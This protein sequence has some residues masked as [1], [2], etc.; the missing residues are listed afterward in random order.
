MIGRAMHRG[1]D[2]GRPAARRVKRPPPDESDA[3]E[4]EVDNDE[5]DEE[6]RHRPR[7][8][9]KTA[10]VEAQP[11]PRG[12]GSSWRTSHS[13]N[14]NNN[15]NNNTTSR[16][17]RRTRSWED[18]EADAAADA[19]GESRSSVDDE[20]A[21]IHKQ[22]QHLQHDPR[23]EA[24]AASPDAS[25]WGGDP[26]PEDGPCGGGGRARVRLSKCW[27]CT[28]ANSK[29]AKQVSAFVCANAGCMDPT[30]MADQI[31]REVLKEVGLFWGA[32]E[33]HE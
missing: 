7:R 23:S 11:Q 1:D 9:T 31:K 25:A 3:D 28:F 8:R 18:D 29:M 12:R 22:K 6:A 17:G 13:N 15:N 19:A 26:H 2:E 10:A 5:D 30:I 16:R 24:E 32:V 21:G 4:D 14:N 27:L 33:M 20:T